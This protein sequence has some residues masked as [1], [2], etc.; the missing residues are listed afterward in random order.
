[1]GLLFQ[2]TPGFYA[3]RYAVA[4]RGP[5]EGRR[6]N[7]LPAFMPGDTPKVKYGDEAYSVSIHSRLLC[8]EI[9]IIFLLTCLVIISFNPLPAFMPGDTIWS[10]FNV[11]RYL[12]S[13]HSRL[14]CREI[15]GFR[16]MI[17]DGKV[18]QSTPGFYAGRYRIPSF[19]PGADRCF[20]PLPAF[21]P[22]DTFSVSPYFLAHTVSIHSRLLCREILKLHRVLPSGGMFQSTPGFYAGRY[23]NQRLRVGG[24]EGF[25]PLPAFMPGDTVE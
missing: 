5:L 20:N 13:I 16:K 21:M 19:P 1:M 4:E 25:N 12:V 17:I 11:S 9:L 23:H 15:R 24:R 3:G 22:G 2:S 8:R 7:P 18:F 10:Y 6:F 14:L